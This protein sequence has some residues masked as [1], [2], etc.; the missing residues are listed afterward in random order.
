MRSTW[1]LVAGF[2][3]AYMVWSHL[4]PT[5][6]PTLSPNRRIAQH[7]DEMAHLSKVKYMDRVHE[8]YGPRKPRNPWGN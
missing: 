7:L 3:L 2:A 6:G 5:S 1:K 8:L 4:Q